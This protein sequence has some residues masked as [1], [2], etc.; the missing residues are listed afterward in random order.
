MGVETNLN[1]IGIWMFFLGF[2]SGGNEN[3]EKL[4]GKTFEN[5]GKIVN[6]WN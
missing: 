6:L 2:L 5:L 3:V 1:E 4:D